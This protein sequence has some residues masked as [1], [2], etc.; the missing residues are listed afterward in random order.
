MPYWSGNFKTPA[1]GPGLYSGTSTLGSTATCE[2][3]HSDAVNKAGL[4]FYA[5]CGIV[6]SADPLTLNFVV[7]A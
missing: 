4:F 2:M 3:H 6:L 7:S 1:G 5:E